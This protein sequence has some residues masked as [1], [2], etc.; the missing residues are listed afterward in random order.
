MFRHGLA[1]GFR[2]RTQKSAWP[3]RVINSQEGPFSDLPVEMSCAAS[4]V[5]ISS[6]R[7]VDEPH[8][9]SIESLPDSER[10]RRA[11]E[12]LDLHHQTPRAIA[13]IG[14]GSNRPSDRAL[15]DCRHRNVRANQLAAHRGGGTPKTRTAMGTRA[16]CPFRWLTPP[17]WPT[18]RPMKKKHPIS[19]EVPGGPLP[20]PALGIRRD[21]HRRKFRPEAPI[22]EKVLPTPNQIEPESDDHVQ[23]QV[24]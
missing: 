9:H 19:L 11:L 20:T 23:P 1:A 13:G 24:R 22:P 17:E 4:Q 6:R 16:Q 7:P 14:P 18:D 21:S 15:L 8:R 5:V 12:L 3:N 10:T 2:R